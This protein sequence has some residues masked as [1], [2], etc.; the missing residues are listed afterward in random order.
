MAKHFIIYFGLCL[1]LSVSVK[2]QISHGGQP[3]PLT[4]TKS[5][6]EDLFITM[7]PFD[8]AEQLRL[9]SL[10]ATDLR[11][12]FRFAYKF[13]TD[14]TPENSGVRFILPD[15]TKVWRLGIRSEG[16][17]SL[18]I[19]FSKYHLPEGARVFLYNSNQSEVLGSFN[20]LN[21]SERAILPVAPIGG[22][23]LIVEYQEPAGVA[24]PGKLAIGEVNHGYRNF[25]V[26]EP[27]PDFTAF[28]CMPV[29]ACYQD[30]TTRYDTIERSVVLMIINVTTGCTGTLVNNTANDGKPYLLTASHCLNNQFQIKNPDYEEVAGNIVCYFNY[31]SPQCSPV[32]PGRTDQTVASAHFRAVNELTDMALLELQ[33]TPPADYR[34]YYAGW[35]AQDAGTAPYTCIHH[36]GGSLKRL[37]LAEGD[38]ELTSYKIQV[39]DFNENSH[40]KVARWA[41]GCTAGGSSGS[42][43]FD[44]DN[45]VIGGLT[46]GASSCLNP[47]ED[48]FFSIQKSWSEPADSSKQ[49]KCWLD[50]VGV[51]A[52]VCAGMDPNEGGGTANEEIEVSTEV[53]LSVDRYR[54]TIRIGFASPVS[55]AS[56]TLVSLT[57]KPVR[58]YS[59]TGQQVTLPIGQVPA[60]MC[61]VKIVYNNKLYTQKVLF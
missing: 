1:F 50:P 26:S 55:Q 27:Q 35:N 51:A 12:G 40:W 56:L 46:G 4:A 36:P 48:F 44:G 14:Y 23:E 10:E 7:P 20:H 6:T 3:L 43:L 25:R 21:N 42:P 39:A 24:F 5:Q 31:N 13:M 15:G 49:L 52:P 19:M 37:N 18:N 17:L 58:H 8:L 59:I 45:R 22:D 57:G 30:S 9:D 28:E 34:V 38:V 47:A 54:H 41:T 60:G 32:E 16:A 11:S 29:I 53:S 61:I 2:A 33:D